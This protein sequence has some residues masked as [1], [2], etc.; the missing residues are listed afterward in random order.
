LVALSAKAR[1]TA[2]VEP[3]AGQGQISL[4]GLAGKAWAWAKLGKATAAAAA[5]DA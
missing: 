4:M 2:S 3:P 5:A 1:M